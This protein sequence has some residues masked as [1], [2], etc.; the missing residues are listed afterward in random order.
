[1]SA[2]TYGMLAAGETPT[3]KLGGFGAGAGALQAQDLLAAFA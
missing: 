3:T 2:P 1:L